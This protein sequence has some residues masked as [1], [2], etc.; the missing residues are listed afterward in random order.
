MA[1][2]VGQ[3]QLLLNSLPEGYFLKGLSAGSTDL[4]A[5]PLT[6][7]PIDAPIRVA[8]TLG[9]SPK[10]RVTGRVTQ[11]A[12]SASAPPDKIALA[13]VAFTESA[14]A[15]LRPDGS[16]EFS[17]VTPGPYLARI[18]LTSSVS[19]TPTLITIPNR[20]VNDLEI[21]ISSPREISGRIA[22]DGN[23]PPPKFSLLLVRGSSLP[24][25]ENR[26]GQ[27]ASIPPSALVNLIQSGGSAGTHV[28]QINVNALPDGSFKMKVPDGEYRV[29]TVPTGL[30]SASIPA[31][32]FLRSLR[33]NSSD[34]M[35]E[36]LRVSEKESTQID[37]GFG[38]TAPN[39]WVKL[40]GRVSG[41]DASRNTFRVALESNLTSAIETYIDAEG[42]FEFPAVLQRTNYTV[43]LVPPVPA[44]S[45]PLVTVADKDVTDVQIVLPPEREMTVRVTV[46]GNHPVP[47]FGLT[48]SSQSNSMTVVVRPEADGSFKGK[49]PEDER[50]VSIIGLPLGYNVSSATFGSAN[51]LR[52]PLKIGG[53]A[54]S[55]IQVRL[56]VD[57]AVSWGSVRGRVTGL[58]IEKGS[59]R[60]VL[61]GVDSFSAFET[62]VN[63]DGSFNFPRLPQGTY[64]PSLD[65]AIV[66]KRLSSAPIV[67]TGPDLA[68]IEIAAPQQSG[69]TAQSATEEAPT[70]AVA[71]DFPGNGRASAN[72]SAAVANLRTINTALVT[73]LSS[74]NGKYGNLQDLVQAGLLDRT[75]MEAKSGFHFSIISIG[76]EYAAAAIPASPA[77]GR[78]GYFSSPDAVVRYSTF[79]PLAPPQ[80]SGRPVQ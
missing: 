49:F 33:A 28:L 36:P 46:E 7:S 58:D 18:G 68:G 44:A 73:Y 5:N 1:L 48:L 47:A 72:E 57:P 67:V 51:I 16:F 64:M 2:P 42:K 71:S 43:R 34:L 22:V 31:A 56:A 24:V 38:T 61:N 8:I 77:T 3:Y 59:V 55:E 35:A 65:G 69:S 32:Y 4:L 80:Q 13:G 23:G 66:A 19:S 45:S 52:Q 54:A 60:L 63:T 50:R 26:R 14:E 11:P 15:T 9:M 75:F 17:T 79:E 30:P 78:F 41:L 20:N 27:L 10:V 25:E 76:S 70:G 12:Q 37:A 21:P 39:S 62:A 74:A 40:S 53:S 6:V 29:V